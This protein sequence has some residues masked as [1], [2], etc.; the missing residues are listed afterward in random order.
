MRELAK[1]KLTLKLSERSCVLAAAYLKDYKKVLRDRNYEFIKR[2]CDLGH[3]VIENNVTV[4]QG[5]SD[6]THGI[7]ININT[8]GEYAKGT[9]RLEGRDILFIEFGAGIHYNG[10]AGQ[11][12]NPKGAELGYTIGSYGKGQG[13]EDGWFY[14]DDTGALM[15]SQGTEATMPMYKASV[16]I[17]QQMRKIAKE[18]FR[19]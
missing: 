5:D 14:Y 7:S 18:V 19:L 1:R 17:R 8:F 6:P 12:P 2:L 11:S 9:V 3:T 4:F 15:Y 16:E 13:K 10:A